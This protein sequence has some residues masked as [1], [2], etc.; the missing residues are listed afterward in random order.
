MV[1]SG[2]G[3]T[4]HPARAVVAPAR[5]RPQLGASLYRAQ[6]ATIA[7]VDQLSHALPEVVDGERRGSRSWA[8]AGK[9]FAWER[10]FSKADIRRF[11]DDPVPAGPIIAV[12]V[13]D[14]VDKDAVLAQGQPGFF[15]IPV[16][17]RDE[18]RFARA[19]RQMA[20]SLLRAP[21]QRSGPPAHVCS[22]LILPDET[23]LSPRFDVRAV[24]TP[25]VRAPRMV[26]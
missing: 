26:P 15:T 8:V 2:K 11:G 16:I 1:P 23:G 17:D 13:E 19:S 10:P 5:V 6:V 9:T 12:V 18:A 25:P 22:P 21:E 24:A 14:L 3:T 4:A 20:E 7:D